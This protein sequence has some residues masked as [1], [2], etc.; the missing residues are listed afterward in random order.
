MDWKK[1]HLLAGTIFL[2][3]AAMV[4]GCRGSLPAQADPDQARAAL[5]SALDAWQKGQ[6]I[7]KLAERDPPIHFNDPKC[8]GGTRLVS[9]RLED[10]AEHHGQA[11]RITAVLTFDQKDGAAKERKITYLVDIGKAVVIVPD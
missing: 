9:Y 3:M 8:R 5:T 7:E 6:E 1:R 10:G 11:A 2:A 4:C